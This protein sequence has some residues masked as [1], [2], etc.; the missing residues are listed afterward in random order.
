VKT[1]LGLPSLTFEPGKR[2]QQFR[3]G[4]GWSAMMFDGNQYREVPPELLP[5]PH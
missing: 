5:L 2:L 4:D 1:A 3:R